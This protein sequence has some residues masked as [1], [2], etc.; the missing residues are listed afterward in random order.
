MLNLT[1]RSNLEEFLQWHQHIITWGLAVYV[2]E[3]MQDLES[4]LGEPRRESLT[5]MVLSAKKVTQ[6]VSFDGI[7]GVDNE[8]LDDEAD[9][10][11][12]D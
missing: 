3:Y 2:P 12:E 11:T 6:P 9:L 4:F 7:P 1:E 5:A 8:E 10:A